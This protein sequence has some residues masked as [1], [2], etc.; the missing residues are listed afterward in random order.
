MNCEKSNLLSIVEKIQSSITL[1]IYYGTF[2]GKKIEIA[3]RVIDVFN[4]ANNLKPFK[5]RVD[6]KVF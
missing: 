1:P 2:E 6:Y 4:E 3:V 5:E